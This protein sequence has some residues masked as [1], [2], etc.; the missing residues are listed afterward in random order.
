[1]GC[2][3]SGSGICAGSVV[4][5]TE[6]LRGMCSR[7]EATSSAIGS[8]AS[9]KASN[10]LIRASRYR[11]VKES[12]GLVLVYSFREHR[13]SLLNQLFHRRRREEF[14]NERRG[15]GRLSVFA[16]HTVVHLEDEDMLALVVLRRTYA[17]RIVGEYIFT[18][19]WLL[20]EAVEFQMISGDVSEGQKLG[21]KCPKKKERRL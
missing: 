14:R 8:S 18:G 13:I 17:V 12:V 5:A 6:V 11:K 16:N 9:E 10:N 7:A 19:F 1:M 21:Q 4:Q 15:A 20:A 2:R 3:L